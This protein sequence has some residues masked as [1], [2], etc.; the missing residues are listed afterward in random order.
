MSFIG[1]VKSENT[2]QFSTSSWWIL[3]LVLLLYVGSTAAGLAFFF[4]AA[5]TGA[6]PGSEGAPVLPEESLPSVLYSLATAMGY[7]FP[8]LIGTLMVTTE[9][10]HKTLTPTFLATPRRGRVLT[11]KV[12]VGIGLGLL[13][14]VI[15]I[16][17]ST[18]PSAGLLALQGVDTQLG[19]TDIWAMLGRMLAA[20]VLWVLIGIG[21]GA[22]VRNQIVAI[23]GALV[24]TQFLEPVV[25]TLVPLVEGAGDI[26][27]FLPGAAS[28]ALVGASLYTSAMVDAGG[29]SAPSLE[30]WAGGLVLLGL[31]VVLLLLA[32]LFS[33]RRD[34]A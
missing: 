32:Q 8:L 6:L 25:R 12:I 24:F 22:L 31:A 23:V 26:V 18:G 10:R 30:W 21:V 27:Q 34:V 9:I 11:A 15:G 2:K 7:V 29:G 5:A 14:G 20:F 1:T 4:A 28:D 17:A 19:D 3:A 13:Y 16:V 33:W